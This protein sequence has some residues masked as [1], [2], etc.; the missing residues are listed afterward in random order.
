[1]ND[2]QPRQVYLEYLQIQAPERSGAGRHQQLVNLEQSLTNCDWDD[3]QSAWEWNNLAVAA[4][5]EAE[6]SN[7]E[8]TKGLYIEMAFNALQTGVN[9]GDYPLCQAH[10]ALLYV[11]L[12]DEH[13]AAEIAFDSF[14]NTLQPAYTAEIVPPGIVYLPSGQTSRA[15]HLQQVLNTDNG[16]FQALY[17]L[18]EVLWRT[19]LHTDQSQTWRLLHLATQLLPQNLMLNLRLGVYSLGM[20]ESEGLLYLHRAQAIAS[21]A[22]AATA[23]DR[24]AVLHALYLAYT[25]LGQAITATYWLKKAQAQCQQH[26]EPLAWKWTTAIDSCFTYVALADRNDLL[27][28]EPSL[29]SLST[30]AL[31]ID[32]DWN[33]PGMEF[34]RQQIQP[35][36]TV[37]D[38]GAH[39]GVYTFSA[40]QQVGATGRV[41]AIE[42]SSFHVSC[43]QETIRLNQLTWVEVQA[44][45]ASDQSGKLTLYLQS[46]AEYHQVLGAAAEPPAWE[47]ETEEVTCFS[48]DDLVCQEQVTSL[49]FLKISTVGHE[50]MVL[51]GAIQTLRQF[52]PTIL[53]QNLFNNEPNLEIAELLTAQGYQLFKYRPYLQ[54][55]MP[56][57]TAD[58]LFNVEKVIAMPA[59]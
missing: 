33:E 21:D 51:Q 30:R 46:P 31:I 24:S 19:Q 49:D 36:M 6:N 42:P 40:A 29:Q 16:Y 45:A 38:V 12:A 13:T 43:L 25:D 15:A 48:V 44:G 26:P 50:L 14:I 56:I 28:I 53:Y 3:P 27:A 4:L 17:L 57:E 10:L 2:F 59:S 37:I 5:V 41:L 22:R 7:N 54:E 55:L 20:Q 39:V 58:D 52:S 23:I 1:M 9:I 18:T 35:G 32:G 11:M 47:G 8:L 34:W